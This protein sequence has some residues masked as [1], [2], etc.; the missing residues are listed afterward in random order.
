MDDFE[1]MSLT[2]E[3][4]GSL[5]L[6]NWFL[7]R[8]RLAEILGRHLPVDDARLRVAPATMIALVVRNI[9]LSHEPLYALSEWASPYEPSLLELEAEDLSALNDDRVGRTLDRLFDADRASLLTELVV[10]M[11]KEFD[12]DVSR[13]HNDSTTVTFH[14]DYE[15]ATGDERGGHATPRITHG[16]N[17]DHRQDLKQL[18]AILSVTADGA[19][20]I[21]FRCADGNTSDDTTHV[22]TWDTLRALVGTSSFTY[23]AD[24]KLCT[25]EAMNHIHTGGGRF[26]TVMPR[27]RRE[28]TW[29]RDYVQG[30]APEWTEAL[31]REGPRQGDPEEV[32][33]TFVAPL[34]SKEGYRII[35]VHSTVKAARDATTRQAR[36]EAGLKAMDVVAE[37]LISPKSRLRTRVAVEEAAAAALMKVRATRWVTFRVHEEQ[38]ETFSQERRGRP[39]SE[40]RYRKRVTSVFRLETSINAA[41]VAYDA[42]TDGMFPLISDADELAP[43]TVLEFYRYQPNLERRHHMLKGPQLVAPV[44]IEQPHRIEALLLCHFFAMV[45]EAL[46]EREIRTSMAISGRKSLPLYPESRDCPSPSAPRILE[47][48]SDAQRHHLESDGMIVKHFDPTLT[49]LQR[50]VLELLHVP[51]SVYLL[52]TAD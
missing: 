1:R 28:D 21:A 3:K 13:L 42:A 35:W 20:P 17:K 19:V 27:T 5:P 34:P 2:H 40:T 46:I 6:V 11:I 44:Y 51:A 29:F 41:T 10:H 50:D 12:L 36:I 49:S 7:G 37:K 23:V 39:G 24:S 43:A 14:G 45:V 30:H 9:V 22:E 48:F 52:E 25:A 18:L 38:R 33:R 26:I 8:L 16:F 4:L 47:I 31:R 32:W 15:N